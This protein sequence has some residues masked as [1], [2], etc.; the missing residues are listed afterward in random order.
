M[1]VGNGMVA[2]KFNHYC[3]RDDVI[4]FASGVSNSKIAIKSEF[5][6]EKKLIKNT[7]I[8]NIEK[9]LIYFSTFNLYDPA[10]KTSPYCLHKLDMEKFIISNAPRYNI[11]RLG[12]VAGSLAKEYT[13]LSFLF[14][15]IKNGS[16]F[17]LWKYATRNIIDIDDV[18]KICTYIIDNDLYQNDITNICNT[19][20]TS[21]IDL[22]TILESVM[23]KKANYTIIKSGDSPKFDN[24]K[25]KLIS[26]KLGISFDSYYVKNL[27]IKYYSS[28]LNI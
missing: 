24:D 10:E 5:A 23:K 2:S 19:H 4:I 15:S 26:K 8:N 22:V 6:R 1:V 14:N 16:L 17:K 11:F 12:H 20:N 27:I 13:I 9:K 18:S 3:E 28:S 21:I 7:L 25:I